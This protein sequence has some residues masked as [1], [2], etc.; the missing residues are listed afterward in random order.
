MPLFC[1]HLAGCFKAE[2]VLGTRV[3]AVGSEFD[4]VR[5]DG[6]E[7]HGLR[8]ERPDEAVHVFVCVTHP[9][10]K[11]ARLRVAITS[12]SIPCRAVANAIGVGAS[13]KTAANYARK[14]GQVILAGFC[15]DEVPISPLDWIMREIE[16]KAILGYYDGVRRAQK[17]PERPASK[18]EPI[19]HESQTDFG[20]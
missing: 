11:E 13:F 2:A 1:K 18:A 19:N 4:V 8:K 9:S 14:G 10:P 7:T 20:L 15:E 12:S 16:V 3:E 6:F 17:E 5:R